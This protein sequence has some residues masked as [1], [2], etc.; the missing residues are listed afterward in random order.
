[1]IRDGIRIIAERK[2]A[3]TA[4]NGRLWLI[5]EETMSLKLFSDTFGTMIHVRHRS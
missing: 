4:G 3:R 5:H 1:M 2:L